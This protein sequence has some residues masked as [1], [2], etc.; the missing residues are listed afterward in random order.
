M[1]LK[2]LQER[3]SSYLREVQVVSSVKECYQNKE[4]IENTPMPQ[5]TA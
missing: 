2:I 3:Y 5:V 4:L 1:L